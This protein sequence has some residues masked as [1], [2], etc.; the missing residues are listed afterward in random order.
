MSW[1]RNPLG[2]PPLLLVP[3]THSLPYTLALGTQRLRGTFLACALVKG[4]LLDSR[5]LSVPMGQWGAVCIKGII[6][7]SVLE[8]VPWKAQDL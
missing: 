4:T 7:R 1:P 3:C 8:W 5:G 2:L 6:G